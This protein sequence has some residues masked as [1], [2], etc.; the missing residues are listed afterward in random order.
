M[1]IPQ[2]AEFGYALGGGGAKA[3]AELGAMAYLE[4]QGIHPS[5]FSGSSMGCV[6]A[7]LLAA[8]YSVHDLLLFY[9]NHKR[10]DFFTLSGLRGSNHRLAVLVAAMCRDKG[11]RN[12]EDLPQ[13]VYVP[14]TIVK[15]GQK[16]ILRKGDIAEVVASSTAAYDI[17]HH[18]V[19]DIAIRREIIRQSKGL[20]G[21]QK[22][23]YLEDSC[24]SA[25][26][27]FELLDMIRQECPEHQNKP[28]YDFAFDVCSG[29]RRSGFPGLD[30]F[31]LEVYVLDNNRK[32]FFLLHGQGAYLNLDFGFTQTNFTPKALMSAYRKGYRYLRKL[33][34]DGTIRFSD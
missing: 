33:F 19:K 11:Y 5:Y 10:S 31:N 7:I 23:L 13:K 21:K 20:Y 4:K 8:G 29:Y 22:F 9:R 12:L 17:R 32:D 34:A 15:T 14:V 16:V 24:Y 30:R 1:E 2:G 26:V 3:Y 25:N 18:L 27:P 6:N 28:Y